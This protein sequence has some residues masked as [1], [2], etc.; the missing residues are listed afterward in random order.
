MG[1]LLQYITTSGVGVAD[2]VWGRGLCERAQRYAALAA[3][4]RPDSCV[5]SEAVH[6]L[7]APCRYRSDACPFPE[8]VPPP[9]AQ[10][11]DPGSSEGLALEYDRVFGGEGGRRVPVLSPC[12]TA[13]LMPGAETTDRLER[14]YKAWGYGLYDDPLPRTSPSHIS[15][16]LD[17]VAH[18]LLLSCHGARGALE[19]ARSF[20]LTELQGWAPLLA[21]AVIGVARHPALRYAAR[22]LETFLACERLTFLSEQPLTR[23]RA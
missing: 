1:E 23:E 5:R 20:H 4:L 6:L 18:C 19:A 14:C 13:Y 2:D 9:I 3:L 17:F 7:A 22:T 11:L 10:G 15:S 12:A 21:A 16:E 8:L